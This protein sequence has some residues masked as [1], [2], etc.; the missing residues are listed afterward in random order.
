MVKLPRLKIEPMGRARWAV[1]RFIGGRCINLV[2]WS[3]VSDEG[4]P[5]VVLA[6][7][8][9]PITEGSLDCYF[10]RNER[11]QR[12]PTYQLMEMF[13]YLEFEKSDV[14]IASV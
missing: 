6:E 14:P 9:I 1:S 10:P 11:G 12:C 7:L 13:Y 3:Y 8:G 2:Q 4:H 5:E